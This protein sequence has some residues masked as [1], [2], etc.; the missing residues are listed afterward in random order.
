M[1]RRFSLL[2]VSLSLALAAIF[3]AAPQHSGPVSTRPEIVVAAKVPRPAPELKIEQVGGPTLSLSQYRGKAVALAFVMT[4]CPHCQHFSEVLNK[5][6]E[7][8]GRMPV[9]S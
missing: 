4:T 7:I 6:Y 3:A 8:Y 5:M 1:I 9:S 2:A